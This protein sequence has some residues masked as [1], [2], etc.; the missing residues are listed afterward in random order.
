MGFFG[1]PIHDSG[2]GG[3]GD[4]RGGRKI[5]QTGRKGSGAG[6]T[7]R[8]LRLVRVGEIYQ[9]RISCQRVFPFR[10]HANMHGSERDARLDSE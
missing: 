2:C 5:K 7:N 1:L 6:D 8:W 9:P 10:A 4:H 3:A